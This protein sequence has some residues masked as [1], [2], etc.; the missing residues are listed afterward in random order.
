MLNSNLTAA[1]HKI[2]LSEKQLGRISATVE[3]FIGEERLAG[4]VTLVARRGKVA[5]F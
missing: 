5:H 3:K 1:P 2:G 4:A